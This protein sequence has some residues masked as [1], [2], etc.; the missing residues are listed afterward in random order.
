MTSTLVKGDGVRSVKRPTLVTVGYDPHR[1][2]MGLST[3]CHITYKC[4]SFFLF[5]VTLHLKGLTYVQYL[6]QNRTLR[7]FVL[8]LHIVLSQ[9]VHTYK[10][11]DLV[12]YQFFVVLNPSLCISPWKH[13]N[14]AIGMNIEIPNK[15]VSLGLK[16]V[17]NTLNFT[18][19][20]G[21][22]SMVDFT[23]RMVAC[24]NLCP[25]LR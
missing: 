20:H 19:G 23:A 18:F 4:F 11:C 7:T 6:K 10:Q 15:S 5:F 3:I 13:Q 16:E 12:L 24:S 25:K 14:L 1:H 22:T 17:S 9:F 2:Q 8:T 21:S